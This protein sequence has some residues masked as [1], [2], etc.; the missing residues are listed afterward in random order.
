MSNVDI[1]IVV[2]I[3]NA[4]L[5]LE[6]TL[7]SVYL[8]TYK[9]Y[10]LILINDGSTDNSE[11]ICMK[12]LK[13]DSRAQYFFRNNSG[14]SETRN[15]GIEKSKGKYICFIDSDDIL[16]K[17]YLSDFI[18][19]FNKADVELGCCQFRKFKGS[20]ELLL[21]QQET[22]I[23]C[24]YKETDKYDILFSDYSGYLWN[25]M[26]ITKIIKENDILFDQSIGMME[27]MLFIFQYLK[28]VKNVTCLYKK[29]YL[30]RVT[31]SS[32]SKK[33]TNI[34][35]F[36]LFKSLDYIID[37]KKLYSQKF[38]N[39]LCFYYLFYLCNAKFRL[40]YIKNNKKYITIQ[41]D[42][43]ER[44]KK[45]KELYQ[46]LNSK[47]RFKIFIY[48]NFNYVSFKLKMFKDN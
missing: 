19:L 6:D 42:I 28:F 34:K 35:W 24:Q 46:Y 8:Q 7:E 21:N 45:F 5:Y 30:Y 11:K 3:Y 20:S 26:F 41:Q 12:Y 23:Y 29:N 22:N 36:S 16:D 48:K 40:K 43:K 27:D 44:N 4:E 18:E 13:K 37:N 25:K 47:Q 32:A 38:Y 39:T 9:N 17:N 33:L 15:F 2:P 14:V 1:S 10:E 31:E